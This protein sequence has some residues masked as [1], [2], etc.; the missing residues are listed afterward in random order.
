[1]TVMMRERVNS[2]EGYIAWRPKPEE[3][4]ISSAAE[5]CPNFRRHRPPTTKTRSAE[6]PGCMHVIAHL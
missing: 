4:C 1:M 2:V 5:H 6:L 3:T